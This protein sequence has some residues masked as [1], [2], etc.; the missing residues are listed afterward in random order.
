MV[1]KVFQS[2]FSFG[3]TLEMGEKPCKCSILQ[4]TTFQEFVLE[5]DTRRN[6]WICNFHTVFLF[7]LLLCDHTHQLECCLLKE[8]DS[9]NCYEWQLMYTTVQKFGVTQIIS[10]FP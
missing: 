6:D 5:M 10:C 2:N 7:V 9:I 3:E 8:M 4:Y 1:W